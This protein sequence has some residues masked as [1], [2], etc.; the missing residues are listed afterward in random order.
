[1]INRSEEISMK[2]A[3]A[4]LAFL[5]ASTLAATAQSAPQSSW[6]IS[7]QE[8]LSQSSKP[9]TKQQLALMI[10]NARTPAE[11]QQIADYYRAQSRS[12]LAES[13]K[14]AQLRNDYARNPAKGVH[15]LIDHCTF[16]MK[17]LKVKSRRAADLASEHEQMAKVAAQQEN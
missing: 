2:R 14:H 16:L 3:I 1:M 4:I 12:F 15:N 7:K 11:H 13:N 17:D 6:L 5:S 9:I 10:D 8:L